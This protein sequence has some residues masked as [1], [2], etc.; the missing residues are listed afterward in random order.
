MSSELNV[1]SIDIDNGKIDSTDRRFYYFNY[2]DSLVAEYVSRN[3]KKAYILCLKFFNNACKMNRE[4]WFDTDEYKNLGIHI[5][6]VKK[7]ILKTY[8]KT[9][10]PKP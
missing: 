3:G 5:G 4:I 1:F 6:I 7:I 9:N 8:T 2:C 10:K